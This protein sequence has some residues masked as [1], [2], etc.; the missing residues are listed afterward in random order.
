MTLPTSPNTS[1][2]AVLGKGDTGWPVFALQRGLIT[3]GYDV[4]ADGDYG[5]ETV[6]A[7]VAYQHK[8]WPNDS[9][10]W[11]GVAGY[12]TQRG[13]V[14]NLDDIIHERNPALPDGL[15]R[16]FAQ[17]E[18]GNYLSAVNWTVAGGVDCGVMQIRVYGPPYD[19]AKLRAAY[20]PGAAMQQTADSWEER[21]NLYRTYT[22]SRSRVEH[23]KRCAALAHNWPYAAEQY[24]KFGKLPNPNNV[25]TWVP[26][27]LKFSDGVP[28]RTWKDWAEFYAMGGVHG[29]GAVTRYVTDWS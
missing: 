8:R 21:Y 11:D 4:T 10:Q 5:D 27:G 28:V 13:I 2:V 26:S 25:A 14:A 24:A 15:M 20:A 22:F 6:A 18:G 19:Q 12:N 1:L 3:L 23:A 9:A 7:V 17:A 29:E 16:G